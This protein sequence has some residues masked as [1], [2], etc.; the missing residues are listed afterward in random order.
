M[1]NFSFK[2]SINVSLF[3]KKK[4]RVEVRIEITV[5]ERSFLS[6]YLVIKDLMSSL[7]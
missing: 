2:Y 7:E 6:S 4:G 5:A 3:T 1:S